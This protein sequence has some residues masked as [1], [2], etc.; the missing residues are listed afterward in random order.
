ML[1]SVLTIAIGRI[2]NGLSVV[3]Q[4]RGPQPAQPLSELQWSLFREEVF[5]LAE[6][7][8]TVVSFGDV[9]GVTSDQPDQEEEDSYVLVVINAD[10]AAL[11][12]RLAE[13]LHR[14]GATSACFAHDADH[15]PVF[16]TED[17]F[18]PSVPTSSAAA[19]APAHGGYPGTVEAR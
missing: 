13:V 1:D 3:Q 15:E 11:R 7:F 4:V 16:D 5:T 19:Y 14:Y 8:G 6:Q 2:T 9:I 12:P 17:G 10:V 18:R